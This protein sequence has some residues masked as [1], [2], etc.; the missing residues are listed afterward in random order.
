VFC[1]T[2]AIDLIELPIVTVKDIMSWLRVPSS[3][4]VEECIQMAH[5][6]GRMGVGGYYSR[7]HAEDSSSS[8]C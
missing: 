8:G 1:A 7:R 2:S 3:K 4:E 6:L 5:S